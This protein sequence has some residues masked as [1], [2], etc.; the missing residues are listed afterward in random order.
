[1]PTARR[2][3]DFAGAGIAE[4]TVVQEIG[5]MKPSRRVKRRLGFFHGMKLRVSVQK[6]S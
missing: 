6:R 2:G 3:T 1:M 4:R 5:R